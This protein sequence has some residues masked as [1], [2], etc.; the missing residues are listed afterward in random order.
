M[1]AREEGTLPIPLR[2]LRTAGARIPSK[3]PEYLHAIL[4]VLIKQ[5]SSATPQASEGLIQSPTQPFGLRFA[6]RCR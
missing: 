6:S 5:D 2:M 4:T 1:K 3:H